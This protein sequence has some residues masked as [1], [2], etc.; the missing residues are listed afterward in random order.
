MYDMI[1]RYS[2]KMAPQCGP[3]DGVVHP[4]LRSQGQEQNASNTMQSLGLLE[5]LGSPQIPPTEDDV[6]H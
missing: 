3:D 2:P 4:F 1:C 5:N 6:R